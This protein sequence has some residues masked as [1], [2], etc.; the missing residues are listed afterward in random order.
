MIDRSDDQLACF[1]IPE[2]KRIRAGGI[3]PSSIDAFSVGAK[4]DRVDKP[5][6]GPEGIERLARSRVVDPDALPL[7]GSNSLAIWAERHAKLMTAFV[8]VANRCDQLTR[9]C[10]PKTVLAIVLL[11]KETLAVGTVREKR[12]SIRFE[13]E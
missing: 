7:T 2:T 8:P 11:R 12:I 4:A 1:H 5:F 13:H 3:D 9:C 6:M 10:V